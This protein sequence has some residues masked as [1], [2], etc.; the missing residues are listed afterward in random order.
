VPVSRFFDLPTIVG[1]L[2]LLLLT[3]GVAMFS[4]A[5]ALIVVGLLLLALAVASYL[6]SNI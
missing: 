6:R 2:G 5:L 3:A 4:V 1:S